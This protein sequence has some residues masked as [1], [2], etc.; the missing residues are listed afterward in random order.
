MF[1]IEEYIEKLTDKL[2]GAF[3]ERLLYIGLQGSYLRGEA[4]EN[5]DIDIMTVID[6]LSVGDLNTYR[7]VLISVGD[8][9][10]SCGFICSRAD[11]EHWNPLEICHLLNATNDCFGEL[12]KLVPEYTV[13]DERNYI[14]LSL[15][16]L[17]HELCHRYIHSDREYN[18]SKLPA[19]C[20]TVFY[21]LQHLYY[22]ESGKFI[23]TKCELLECLRGD[24]RKVLE[25]S[26]D[27]QNNGG[28]DFDG[29]FSM[30]FNWC[31]RALAGI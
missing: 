21:I 4:T 18:I 23:Q 26:I 30:L 24:D 7:E 31:R 11:L 15:N 9:D 17:Y 20:K 5:S 19:T 16:N 27:L 6:G 28:C 13:E 8:F 29:A 1:G 2:K 22:L 12:K 14:K 10:K 25:L 3:G